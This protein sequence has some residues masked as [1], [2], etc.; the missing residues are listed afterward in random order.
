MNFT[1]R[2]FLKSAAIAGTA[3]GTI[4]FRSAYALPEKV[5]GKWDAEYDVIIVGSGGAG[6]SAALT[7]VQEGLKVVLLEKLPITGG[8]STICNGGTSWA[9]TDMQKT[10]GY[11]DS[12][13]LFIKD[14]MTVGGG[15]NDLQLVETYVNNGLPT[16]YWLKENGVIF[17]TISTGAGMSVPRQHLVT[18]SLMLKTLNDAAKAKGA[19]FMTQ[20]AAENLLTDENNKV[21]GLRA[22]SR[23]KTINILA[24]KGVILACGGFARSKEMLKRFAP[25]VLNAQVVS[26]QGN[27]GDG[28]KMAWSL[29]ADLI[30][31]P[32][33]KAT[34]GFT[35]GTAI[36]SSFVFYSGAIIVNK[37]G[38]RFT[39]E[40][41]SYKIIGDN[42]LKE[43]DGIGYQVFDSTI[44][45]EAAK[46]ALNN[47]D[48]MAEKGGMVKADSID[49]LA[50]LINVNADN[51]KATIK[52][53]NN[54][55]DN[56]N[57]QFGR[58]G[59]TAGSGSLI[60]LTKAPYYAFPSTAV[61][62]STYCGAKINSNAQ[63]VDV[64][65]NVIKGLYAAGE[66]TGGVHGKAYLSGT[67]LGKGL[68]FGRI[69]AK[70][71][72]KS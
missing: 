43:R 13:E 59:L 31:L 17:N 32:Y 26:G 61:L 15:I 29:G 28:L 42:A 57:D 22:N 70:H 36:L 63:V 71:I 50:K 44:Y 30:D 49:E 6:S 66:V 24:K 2:N 65:G 34:F 23:G 72:A 1:R 52:A 11:K 55:I 5:S 20:T 35:P 16:Y 69:A 68:V 39:D 9:G 40:S 12:S 64:F 48:K 56:K 47:L 37:D 54:G 25:G 41:Q 4:G 62:L 33:I 21:I 58:T 10:M 45:D 60:K 67:S 8:S 7:A 3:F 46:D 19:V 51:L 38:K 27:T 53:Y 14:M 18:P